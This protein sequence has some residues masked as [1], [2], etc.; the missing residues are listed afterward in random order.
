MIQDYINSLIDTYFQVCKEHPSSRGSWKR[1]MK[2][3]ADFQAFSEDTFRKWL[4]SRSAATVNHLLDAG[5]D[6]ASEQK[7]IKSLECELE[8]FFH[9]RWKYYERRLV[10]P[11]WII[12][13]GAILWISIHSICIISGRDLTWTMSYLSCLVG[14]LCIGFAGILFYLDPTNRLGMSRLFISHYFVEA[15]SQWKELQSQKIKVNKEQ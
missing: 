10:L 15:E 7:I 14:G 6:A 11:L 5:M 1:L 12:S 3:R 9:L 2:W 4:A 8:S 13:A